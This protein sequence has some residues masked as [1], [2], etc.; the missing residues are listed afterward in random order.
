[1]LLNTIPVYWKNEN[2]RGSAEAVGTD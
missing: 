2:H 1:V